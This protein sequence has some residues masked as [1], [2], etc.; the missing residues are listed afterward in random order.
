MMLYKIR[1][2]YG[3]KS[4]FERLKE[5][6]LF[7]LSDISDKLQI[8]KCTLKKWTKNNLIKGYKCNN[9]DETLYQWPGQELIIKLRNA[10]QQG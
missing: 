6:K 7:T 9:K 1:R 3:L 8:S 2:A 4:R 10:N 5:Q